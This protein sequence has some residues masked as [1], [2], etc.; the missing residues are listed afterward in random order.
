M[1]SHA[2]SQNIKLNDMDQQGEQGGKCFFADQVQ[3][4]YYLFSQYSFTNTIYSTTSI[5]TVLFY[6]FSPAQY[7]TKLVA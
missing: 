3:T 7:A 2:I 6:D 1:G 4:P 5:T